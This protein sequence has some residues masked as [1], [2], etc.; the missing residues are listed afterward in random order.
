MQGKLLGH[1]KSEQELSFSLT[2]TRRHGPTLLLVRD[3]AGLLQRTLYRLFVLLLNL[4]GLLAY[5]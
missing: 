2:S 1:F 3:R 5:L 4:L